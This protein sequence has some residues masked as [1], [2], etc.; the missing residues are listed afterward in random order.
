VTTVTLEEEEAAF[1]HSSGMLAG[2]LL[3]GKL[4]ASQS[5]RGRQWLVAR[6]YCVSIASCYVLCF[7]CLPA[8]QY[9]FGAA[10]DVRSFLQRAA[11]FTASFGMAVQYYHIPPLV[12]ATFGCDKGLFVAYTDGLAS[13]LAAGIWCF[14]MPPAPAYAWAAVALALLLSAVV[15]MEFLHHYYFRPPRSGGSRHTSGSILLA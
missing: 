12:G 5:D 8:L 1:W 9:S 15:M 3:A 13:V 10:G 4:F 2:L 6:L 14:G 11:L 7:T